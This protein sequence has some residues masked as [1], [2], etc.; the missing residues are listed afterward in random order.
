MEKPIVQTSHP[1]REI[2]RPQDTPPEGLVAARSATRSQE[3]CKVENSRSHAPRGNASYR[4]SRVVG[5]ANQCCHLNLC[6]G[7]PERPDRAFPRGAWERGLCS[8]PEQA[9][10]PLDSP[11]V[12][13][14]LMGSNITDRFPVWQC[15]SGEE[16]PWLWQWLRFSPKRLAES[17]PLTRLMPFSVRKALPCWG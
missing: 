15:S 1:S 8:S 16:P 3:N 4:R 7:T 5:G 12:H 11:A 13:D 17:T 10:R 14:I 6:H 9:A 2:P